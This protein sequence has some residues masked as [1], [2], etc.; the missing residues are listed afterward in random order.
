VVSRHSTGFKLANQG[1]DTRSLQQPQVPSRL[2]L[3]IPPMPLAL[4]IEVIE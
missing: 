4:A 3:T 2:C 1:V